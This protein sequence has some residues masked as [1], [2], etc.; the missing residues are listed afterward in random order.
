MINETAEQPQLP[1]DDDS[2]SQTGSSSEQGP[3]MASDEKAASE[4]AVRDE[5]VRARNKRVRAPRS[6]PGAG[7]PPPFT[8]HSGQL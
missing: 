8:N 5:V 4:Q 1:R 3:S 2:G 6:A 7:S